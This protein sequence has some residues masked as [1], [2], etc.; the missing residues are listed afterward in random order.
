MGQV[1][2]YLFHYPFFFFSPPIPPFSLGIEGKHKSVTRISAVR[3]CLHCRRTQ[4]LPSHRSF[5]SNIRR[6]LGCCCSAAAALVLGDFL[7]PQTQGCF[8]QQATDAYLRWFER[9]RPWM[10]CHADSG[11]RPAKPLC[12]ALW[13]MALPASMS[14]QGEEPVVGQCCAKTKKEAKPAPLLRK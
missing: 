9:E 1:F 7:P 6:V 14:Y 13:A 10:G 11:A 2:Y 8:A 4:R 3:L 12:W 5:I